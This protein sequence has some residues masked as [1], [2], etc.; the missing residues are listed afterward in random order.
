MIVRL[1]F[2]PSDGGVRRQVVEERTLLA[3]FGTHDRMVPGWSASAKATATATRPAVK[4]TA[5][6]TRLRS[7][8][9]PRLTKNEYPVRRRG[10]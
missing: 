4:D 9:P 6:R 1:S 2:A 7:R 3:S 10:E 5:H 8:S